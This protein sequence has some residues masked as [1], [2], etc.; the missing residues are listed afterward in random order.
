M[1]VTATATRRSAQSQSQDAEP[2]LLSGQTA[3]I[4]VRPST[5]SA[6]MPGTASASATTG[7]D[8]TI[9][10]NRQGAVFAAG[11]DKCPVSRACTPEVPATP[12]PIAS[13]TLG[14]EA[15]VVMAASR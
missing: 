3:L 6:T 9:A 5:A 1:A 8:T 2:I 7:S 4:S 14:R 12:P 13:S 11:D 15:G 10:W